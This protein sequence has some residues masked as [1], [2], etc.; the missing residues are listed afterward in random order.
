MN[1]QPTKKDLNSAGSKRALYAALKSHDSRFDGQV[2]VGV[3][4]TGIYCRPVC[5]VKTPKIENC[6]FF[7]TAAEAECAGY[8]PCLLCRPETAPGASTM[9]AAANLARRA[10]NLIRETYTDPQSIERLAARLGYTDRHLRCVFE[11]EFSVSPAQYLQTCRLHLAKALLTDSGLPVSSVAAAAGFGSVRRFN[12][13]FKRHYRMTPS[14]LRKQKGAPASAHGGIVFRLDYRPPYRFNDVLAFFRDRQIEGVERIDG[15]SYERIVR[16]SANGKEC[17][18]WLRVENDEAHNALLVTIDEGLLSHTSQILARIRRQFDT[19]SDP[20]AVMEG[21]ASLDDA[22]PGAVKPGT[23]VPGCFDPFE[24]AMRAILGQQVTV[25]FANTLAARIAKAFGK[26]VD[27]GREGLGFS[28]PTAYDIAAIPSIEDAFGEL[29]VIRSRSRV[30]AEIA[31]GL[32]AGT[33]DFSSG[34]VVVDQ[35]ERLLA[36]KGIGQWTADYMAMRI[37]SDPD[38]FL[39][40][41]VGIKHALPDLSPKERL[42]LA[43]QWR[44][45]R[46]YATLSLWNSLNEKG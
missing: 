39:A 23:R 30:I 44:P 14:A 33:L 22:V 20:N 45:W 11:T 12:E 24:T 26:P 31:R 37:F 16:I 46:S 35:L 6:T 13:V 21:I 40:G 18:G 3:S 15:T 2:F 38:I 8:R 28:F 41:D 29:G 4:S 34:A 27:L 7:A 42:A 9:D 43:E 10:A 36:M 17:I 5:R 19:D 25:A 32:E 1:S